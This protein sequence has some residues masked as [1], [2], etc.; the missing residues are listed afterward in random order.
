MKSIVFLLFLACIFSCENRNGKQE[1]F[2]SPEKLDLLNLANING[3]WINQSIIDTSFNGGG[4]E[5]FNLHP[6]FIEGIGLFN[7]DQMVW[8]SVFTSKDTAIIAME[9][10][11]ADVASVIKE[12][13]S[14][15]IIGKW[16]FLYE[17]ENSA[18]FVNQWNTIIEVMFFHAYYTDVEST[19]F[20][21][22]NELARRVDDLSN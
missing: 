19:L 15:D 20:S 17:G 9:S 16:W 4:G 14:D 22:A 11:I 12:G 10:R 7:S 18:V 13:A 8:V 21:T 1:E 3:F 2:F 5:L 6:G